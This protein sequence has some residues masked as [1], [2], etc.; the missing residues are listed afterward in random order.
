MESFGPAF[1]DSVHLKGRR[2][3]AL[4]GTVKLDATNERAPVV[5]GDGVRP[6]GLRARAFSDDFVL[7]AAWQ[8]DHSIL[9][10]VRGQKLF[11]LFLVGISGD[12]RFFFQPLADVGIQLCEHGLHF[13]VRQKQLA[14]GERVLHSSQQDGLVHF[15]GTLLEF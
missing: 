1:D 8:C 2:L 7:K 6:S 14:A 12:S 15:N 11:A 3:A 9:G 10:F 5:A 13:V 4:V